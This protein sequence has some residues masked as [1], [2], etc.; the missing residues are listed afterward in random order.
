[1]TE[2]G[3]WGVG[4]GG[5]RSYHA[6][7]PRLLQQITISRVVRITNELPMRSLLLTIVLFVLV[8]CDSEGDNPNT[9]PNIPKD[10]IAYDRFLPMQIGNYWAYSYTNYVYDTSF[11][12]KIIDTVRLQ[13]Q[14]FYM[15]EEEYLD[16]SDE[17]TDTSYYRFSGKDSLH[18]I[19]NNNDVLYIDFITKALDDRGPRYPAL[20]WDYSYRDS[21]F[22]GDYDSC[23]S[24]V[25]GGPE[26]TFEFYAPTI[27]KLGLLTLGYHYMLIGARVNDSLIT[28]K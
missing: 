28:W 21:S 14:L 1:M 3:E 24:V 10:T 15:F 19:I 25:F 20:V 5:A 17:H 6:K 26:S 9:T 11:V 22:I 13:G 2:N 8:G 16:H 4:N 27:G 12:L 7:I 18:K 23:R